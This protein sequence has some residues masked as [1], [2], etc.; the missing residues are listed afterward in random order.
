[1][2]I[3]SALEKLF[4]G[5][6]IAGYYPRDALER[7]KLFNSFGISTLINYLG[8]DVSKKEQIS[9]A[10]STYTDLIQGI[11]N[12]KLKAQISI[13][14]TQIGLADNYKLFLS[15]YLKIVKSAKENGVF[16]W[17]DM[18]SPARVDDIIKAYKNAIKYGNTGICIQAYLKRSKY[19][20]KDL[21]KHKAKIRLV[22]GAYQIKGDVVL[23]SKR[24]VNSNYI[25]IM[26][27]LFEQSNDFMIATHDSRIIEEGINLNKK[28][29]KRVTYAMLNGIRNKYAKY[30]ANHKK[31]MAVYVPFGKDWVGF[32]YRRLVEQRHISLIV[33]SLFEKQT[34]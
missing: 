5:R 22:K 19:D 2:G 25:S 18:E 16:V 23:S 11:R 4:A 10:V 30:L 27:M 26:K 24:E 21:M 9:E 17:L 8:E 15:N 1:V 33:R 32:G 6:W 7:T 28:Y 14:P 34:L 3:N 31:D 20:V 29:H 13:K 12:E